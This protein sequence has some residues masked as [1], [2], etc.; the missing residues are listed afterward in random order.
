[1]RLPIIAASYLYGTWQIFSV[2]RT[3]A[4]DAL[5]SPVG[6]GIGFREVLDVAVGGGGFVDGGHGTLPI[7]VSTCILQ[8][9]LRF[10][11]AL[12]LGRGLRV[13]PGNI[14]QRGALGFARLSGCSPW[15]KPQ[16]PQGLGRTR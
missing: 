5:E 16:I 11:D 15:P 8:D 14:G 7:Q 1:M 4:R 13:L 9:L 10:S 6:L 12:G 2:D 3:V